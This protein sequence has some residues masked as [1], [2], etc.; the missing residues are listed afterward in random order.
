MKKNILFMMGA[1]LVLAACSSEGL[2][3]E[4][5]G[6]NSGTKLP[7]PNVVETTIEVKKG[8]ETVFE[9]SRQEIGDYEEPQSL[10][11]TT[12]TL[13]DSEIKGR[14]RQISKAGVVAE[15][16]ETGYYDNT[17]TVEPLWLEGLQSV[18]TENELAYLRGTKAANW[19]DGAIA[20]AEA[21]D[22]SPYIYGTHDMWPWYVHTAEAYSMFS[23]GIHWFDPTRGYSQ[24]WDSALGEWVDDVEAGICGTEVYHTLPYLGYGSQA[25]SW[26]YGSKLGRRTHAEK[27]KE[28]DMEDVWWYAAT[29]DDYD[30]SDPALKIEKFKVITTPTNAI[31]WCFDCNHDGDYSDLVCLVEPSHVVEPEV[32]EVEGEVEVDIHQEQHQN[33]DEIKTSI[34]IRA[35]VETVTVTIPLAKNYVAEAD[36]FAIRSYEGWYTI[37]DKKYP[38]TVEVAHN[39]NDIVIKVSDIP[40]DVIAA[41]KQESND[42]LT[43]EVHSYTVNLAEEP[44]WAAVKKSTVAV[45]VDH[46]CTVKGQITSAVY[47]DQTV[48][49]NQ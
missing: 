8:S 31:Y 11:K 46:T 13:N 18:T 3:N 38:V 28:A 17:N 42:G 34:H 14:Q 26:Y 24:K 2:E 35:Q 32:V 4:E 44:V 47:T 48:Y 49:I 21:I 6:T 37:A 45:G 29:A 23:L 9:L 36:D 20:T 10:P 40:A 43:I 39:D 27:L 22:F 41:L 16:G 12:E 5:P 25:N 7:D 30:T 33:W 1:A 19:Q 15:E